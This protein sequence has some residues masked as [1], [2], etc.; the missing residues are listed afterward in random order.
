VSDHDRFSYPLDPLEAGPERQAFVEALFERLRP[1]VLELI[2]RASPER[3]V[4]L[5]RHLA[6]R[7]GEVRALPG[8]QMPARSADSR[9]QEPDALL[10]LAVELVPA[11]KGLDWVSATCMVVLEKMGH[12]GQPMDR[13]AELLASSDFVLQV[14][15]IIS[16]NPRMESAAE[17]KKRALKSFAVLLDRRIQEVT[18]VECAGWQRVPR[19]RTRGDR[20]ERTRLGWLLD[21]LVDGKTYEDIAAA[22]PS[23]HLEAASIGESVR[24]IAKVLGIPL[25]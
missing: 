13:T 11:L 10:A 25:C 24:K 4:D 1:A 22:Q 3:R 21:H 20:D 15:P 6:S 5:A 16:W 7:E 8:V 23:Q 12:F 19:P 2:G 18:D 17:F 9:L 14:P